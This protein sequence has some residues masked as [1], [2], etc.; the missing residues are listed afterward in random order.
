M[1]SFGVEEELLLVDAKTG[2]LAPVSEQLLG[3]N[4]QAGPSTPGTADSPIAY[5]GA[6]VPELKQEQLEA[7]S[8]PFKDLRKLAA[9][10]RAGRAEAD[11]QAKRFGARAVALG[12]YPLQASTQLVRRPRYQ[13]MEGRYGMTL[14]EQLTCGFHIHVG[15]ASDDEAVA[16]L[17]RYDGGGEP[18]RVEQRQLQGQPRAEGPGCGGNGRGLFDPKV[19]GNQWGQ[20]AVAC[21]EWT[22]RLPSTVRPAPMR[23]AS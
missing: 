5:S 17:D 4:H 11:R 3:D 18:L 15:V 1:R 23:F 8:A 13:A 16:V 22:G 7:V 14:R 6:L 9:G 21:S 2:A 10:L 12:T 19:R 20:G